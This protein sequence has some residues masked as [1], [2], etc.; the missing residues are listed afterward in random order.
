MYSAMKVNVSSIE[1]AFQLA[2]T[3]RYTTVTEVKLR[4]HA[5]GY[6]DDQ[7]EGPL[8]YRQLA[9]VMSKA[10]AAHHPYSQRMPDGRDRNG[11]FRSI[12]KQKASAIA[13][14]G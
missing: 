14:R 4:L 1:R 2:E 9:D 12:T 3:A 10:H 11:K 6:L 7:I 5:E 8:L 13:H